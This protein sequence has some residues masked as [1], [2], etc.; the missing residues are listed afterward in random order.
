MAVCIS[1]F[2]GIVAYAIFIRQGGYEE[3]ISILGTGAVI[4]IV[5]SI[6]ML[7][8]ICSFLFR[9]VCTASL[10][11]YCV[12]PLLLYFLE[13]ILAAV[14]LIFLIVLFG[15]V[16]VFCT[17]SIFSSNTNNESNSASKKS[18]ISKKDAQPRVIEFSGD[19]RFSRGKGGYGIMTP[20]DD[21]IYYTGNMVEHRV[22]FTVK[23]YE[24]GKV[25]IKLNGKQITNI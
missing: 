15:I 22:A 12:I 11:I 10:M 19:V 13:N 21:C 14:V 6:I 18:E 9:Y 25:I 24:Q 1:F 16:M 20:A 2:A 3:Q 7:R 4:I 8:S 23:D 17:L 5:F